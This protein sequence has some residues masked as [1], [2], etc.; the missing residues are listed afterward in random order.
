MQT[1]AICGKLDVI[2][3]FALIVSKY[4]VIMTGLV[5]FIRI[6]ILYG[7]QREYERKWDLL[8]CNC[9]IIVAISNNEVMHDGLVL[10]CLNFQFVAP[11][12]STLC[13]VC[14]DSSF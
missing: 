14:N 3:S 2:I 13:I 12:W 1:C 4:Q 9:Y 7:R 11:R 5:F 6:S 8:R 10:F